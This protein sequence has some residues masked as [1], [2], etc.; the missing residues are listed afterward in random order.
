MRRQI[1]TAVIVV[2]MLVAAALGTTWRMASAQ[3]AEVLDQANS[4]TYAGYTTRDRGLAGQTVTTGVSGF[5]T[6]VE[7][8]VHS[9]TATVS[10]IE[11]RPVG[12][13][14]MPTNTVLATGTIPSGS[15]NQTWVSVTFA[16]QPYFTAGTRYAIVLTS[17]SISFDDTANTYAGGTILLTPYGGTLG[18]NPNYDLF[19]RTYVIPQ[20]PTATP[21]NTP[22]NTPTA[23]PTHT[24]T[25]TPTNTATN[26]PVPPTAT[27]TS[28]FTPVPPTPTETATSTFTPVPPTATATATSTF[29]PAP[30]TA[31]A[32][33]TFTPVPPTAT[34]TATATSIGYGWNGFFPPVDNLP[35]VNT[36]NAG[37]AIP[38]KFS[39]GG[40]F[41]LT[42]FA[43]GSPTVQQVSCDSGG[44]GSTSPLE[45]T[46]TAGNSG[47]QYDP[48][49]QAYT[50]VWKTAKA[51]TGTCRQL[52]ITLRDGTMHSAR[53]Q[54]NGK[55]K[56]AENADNDAAT[57][58]QIF[59]PL[60]S[61]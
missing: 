8:Q 11:V 61:R 15:Y 46:V 59:L 17:G 6:R 29:T 3:S 56:A 57:S 30:P 12:S 34:P 53:F 4:G 45:E 55:V 32:T 9:A 35:I 25:N 33:N 41:G 37:A 31:T 20:A 24:P 23:T 44:S 5:L 28:T 26:T 52:T 1:T 43:S 38:I 48:T 39:L 2:L 14:G 22:T 21:T 40:D 42:I 58:V 18:A 7:L 13:D 50:Y 36:V 19:F 49:T 16:A 54:F 47:L 51:W 27:A 10:T 60:V